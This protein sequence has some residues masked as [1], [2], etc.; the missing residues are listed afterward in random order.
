MKKVIIAKDNMTVNSMGGAEYKEGTYI[1]YKYLE[2]ANSFDYFAVDFISYL[3]GIVHFSLI[4]DT[5]EDVGAESIIVEFDLPFDG[6]KEVL[7]GTSFF[8][9][10]IDKLGSEYEND[11]YGMVISHRVDMLD[12]TFKSL[13]TK[14]ETE[15]HDK[16]S[17]SNYISNHLNQKAIEV[18]VF[19]YVELTI[20]NGDLTFIT[21]DGLHTS[22]YSECYL[23]DLID[24]L[25]AE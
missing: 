23:E 21:Q 25:N 15:L 12:N 20:V 7:K 24:I 19:D 13:K 3:D 2:G 5:S 1:Q 17:Q 8:Q 6:V 4:R 22:L 10:W 9:D 11:G 16:I 14:V 18:N